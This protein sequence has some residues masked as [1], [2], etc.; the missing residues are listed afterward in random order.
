MDYESEKESLKL[1]GFEGKNDSLSISREKSIEKRVREI[2]IKENVPGAEKALTR[3]IENY[4]LSDKELRYAIDIF[5]TYQTRFWD[6]ERLLN[7][8]AT[9][10]DINSIYEVRSI[11]KDSDPDEIVPLELLY[12]FWNE[13]HGGPVNEEDL[14]KEI[15]RIRDIIPL[16][17]LDEGERRIKYLSPTYLPNLLKIIIEIKRE[18]NVQDLEHICEIIKEGFYVGANQYD[19]EE[20]TLIKR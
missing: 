13:F 2:A 18:G 9:L 16:G 5:K 11:V 1:G 15:S 20:D 19:Q 10:H 3:L 8:G 17:M 6:I 12:E 4:S 7:K 14:C